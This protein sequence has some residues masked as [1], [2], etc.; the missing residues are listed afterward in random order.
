MYFNQLLYFTSF[1]I[2]YT[3]IIDSC[4]YLLLLDEISS[5]NKTFVIMPLHHFETEFDKYVIK[6]KIMTNQKKLMLNIVLDI[7]LMT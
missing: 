3:S 2:N 6:G 5:K 4:C 1:F 7:I